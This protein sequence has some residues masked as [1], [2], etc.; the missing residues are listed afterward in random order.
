MVDEDGGSG[1]SLARSFAFPARLFP[2]GHTS[3]I[4][5]ITPGG[6]ILL[7][8]GQTPKLRILSAQLMEVIM[9]SDLYLV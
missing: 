3:R 5:T 1:S 4:P 9:S 7:S 2:P 6:H 8:S